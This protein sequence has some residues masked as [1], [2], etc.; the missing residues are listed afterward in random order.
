MY[1]LAD[2]PS[3]CVRNLKLTYTKLNSLT[4][5][6]NRLKF[7]VRISSLRP[8]WQNNSELLSKKLWKFNGWSSTFDRKWS[9]NNF[10]KFYEALIKAWKLGKWEKIKYKLSD[11]TMRLVENKSVEIFLWCNPFWKIMLHD[12]IKFSFHNQISSYAFPEIA[13]SDSHLQKYLIKQATHEHIDNL[14]IA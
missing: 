11:A 2:L 7:N 6:I 5:K 8:C 3:N 1:M 13:T 4:S 9:W 12:K 10:N 14:V